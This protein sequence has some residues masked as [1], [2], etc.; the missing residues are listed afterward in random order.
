MKDKWEAINAIL[1]IASQ[2]T[3]INS[4]ISLEIYV[5]QLSNL[6]RTKII[7]T[8]VTNE[9]LHEIEIKKEQDKPYLKLE[10]LIKERCK[11]TEKG[12]ELKNLIRCDLFNEVIDSIENH[13]VECS[14][15]MAIDFTKAALKQA[16]IND[17]I[18]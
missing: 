13:K 10:C 6:I 8:D 16:V 18:A 3:D 4:N 12:Y 7:D 14:I 11:L 1:D 15:D 2:K 5:H 9:E 17:A